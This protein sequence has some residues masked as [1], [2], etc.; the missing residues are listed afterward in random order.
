MLRDISKSINLKDKIEPNKY[1]DISSAYGYGG[2]LFEFSDQ[3]N[4]IGILE[5]EFFSVFSDYC[6][7]NNI[8]TQFD[9]F[10]PLLK[11]HLF[12]EGY[13]ELTNMLLIV[14][15]KYSQTRAGS[16]V[17]RARPLQG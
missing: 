12:F 9:R 8:I 16:S 4:N 5:K 3:C 6:K 17:G 10:H 14:F 1:F 15:N 7:T 11:N 13:S 2:P